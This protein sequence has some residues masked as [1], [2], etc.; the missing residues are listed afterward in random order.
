MLISNFVNE[1]I[2]GSFIYCFGLSGYKTFNCIFFYGDL[3]QCASASV[4]IR[5]E[6]NNMVLSQNILNTEIID[7][8]KLT[9]ITVPFNELTEIRFINLLMLNL[10]INSLN[11]IMFQY[12][13]Y[14]T[15]TYLMLGPQVGIVIK[16]KLDISYYRMLFELYIN[17]LEILM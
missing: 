5:G 8:H 14:Q 16:D 15:F 9:Q 4:F 10:R 1:S 12:N 17:K 3:I 2:D 6:S 13:V 7:K 11:N